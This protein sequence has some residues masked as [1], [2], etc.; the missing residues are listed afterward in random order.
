MTV[1][2]ILVANWS[3]I[4]DYAFIALR[5]KVLENAHQDNAAESKLR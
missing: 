5:G 3:A 4:D 2:G 1:F